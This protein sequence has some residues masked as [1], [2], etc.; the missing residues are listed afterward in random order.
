M[1]NLKKTG[2]E[3][4]RNRWGEDESSDGSIKTPPMTI[5]INNYESDKGSVSGFGFH[6]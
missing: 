6:K 4:R 1:L 2:D 5:H 3:M